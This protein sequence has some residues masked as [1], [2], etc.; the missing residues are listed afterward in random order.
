VRTRVLRRA[1]APIV[2]PGTLGPAAALIGAA[3]LVRQPCET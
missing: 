1:E 2:V 3:A